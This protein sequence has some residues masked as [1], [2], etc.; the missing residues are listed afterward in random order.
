MAGRSGPAR[1]CQRTVTPPSVEVM[2]LAPFRKTELPSAISKWFLVNGF[3]VAGWIAH[4]P[5]QKVALQTSPGPLGLAL[6][7]MAVGSIFGMMAAPRMIGR[8]GA[9][10]AAWMAG[11]AFAFLVPFPLLVGSVPLLGLSLLAFGTMH[12][13]MDVTMNAAAAACEKDADRP[14]MS[15]FHGWFSVGMV[16]GVS[17]GV[18]A[19]KAGLP[20]A[21]HAVLVIAIAAGL[22]LSA[23]PSGRLDRS[24]EG[25][26][27]WLAGE[28]EP[29]DACPVGPGIRVSIPGG[30]YGRL[31][32]STRR[33]VRGGSRRRL[34][35]LRG[36]HRDVGGG[37]IRRRPINPAN[38]RCERGPRRRMAGRVR[39]RRW[40][41]DGCVNRGDSRL[42]HR[43]AG[44]G[45]RRSGAVPRRGRPGPDRPGGRS[46]PRY[47]SG[48]R[49]LPRRPAIGGLHGRGG[50]PA[51]GD[52][53]GHRRRDTA[54]RRGSSTATAPKARQP[55]STRTGSDEGRS[56]STWTGRS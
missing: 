50:R 13:L 52:V 38:R 3:V 34:G 29:A 51:A 56:S 5:R 1:P 33:R 7:C 43:R 18:A 32:R 37:P 47:R 54:G 21:A 27:C 26:C 55:K 46:R 24:A 42:W 15:S 22:L 19:L 23:W 4:I 31:V 35:R 14:L 11:F 12:G 48:I 44:T 45:E 36:L 53:P 17:G 16:A 41:L 6:L 49:R 9:G 39:C 8:L 25:I 28:H 2:F 30:C 10:R 40:A 20:P